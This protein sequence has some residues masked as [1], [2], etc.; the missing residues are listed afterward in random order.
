M[1][2]VPEGQAAI[3]LSLRD[4]RHL[5]AEALLKVSADGQRGHWLSN[6]ATPVTPAT[7]GFVSDPGSGQ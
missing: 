6:S 4:K 7:P 3:M 2:F 5:T 1:S